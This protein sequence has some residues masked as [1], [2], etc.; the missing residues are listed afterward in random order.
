MVQIQLTGEAARQAL[1]QSQAAGFGDDVSQFFVQ[2]LKM[3]QPRDAPPVP[4]PRTHEELIELLDE[5]SASGLF[6]LDGDE[7]M[8]TIRAKINAAIAQSEQ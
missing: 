4:S 7:V 5:G 8:R 2:L 1:A 3:N 6:P